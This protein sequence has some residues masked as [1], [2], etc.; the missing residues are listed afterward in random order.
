MNNEKSLFTII[1][2]KSFIDTLGGIS[3]ENF[4]QKCKGL[5]K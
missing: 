1:R 2:F 5:Q 3:Y 4:R